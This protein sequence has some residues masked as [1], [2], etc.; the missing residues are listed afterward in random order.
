MKNCLDGFT[1]SIIAHKELNPFSDAPASAE[2]INHIHSCP[3]CFVRFIDEILFQTAILDTLSNSIPKCITDI[4]GLQLANILPRKT[5]INLFRQFIN[6]ESAL[7]HPVT[8]PQ[9]RYAMGAS[10][11]TTQFSNDDI[12][13]ET[14]KRKISVKNNS[15]MQDMIVVLRQG[16]VII[17]EKKDS[18]KL[19][20]FDSKILA[21]YEFTK[22]ESIKI[23]QN[24]PILYVSISLD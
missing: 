21:N 16:D 8:F 5:V 22:I 13:V 6:L 14:E 20:V 19:I 1:I 7:P 18:E 4:V 10:S 24:K 17:A 23:I 11:A 12:A 2:D 3:E 9:R 15:E